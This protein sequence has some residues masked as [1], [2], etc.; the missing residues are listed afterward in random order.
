MALFADGWQWVLLLC[1]AWP[2]L[3]GIFC[4]I[5]NIFTCPT[6]EIA[7]VYSRKKEEERKSIKERVKNPLLL[8]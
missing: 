1:S 4:C 3:G 7:C 5:L 2:G 6:G 8:P